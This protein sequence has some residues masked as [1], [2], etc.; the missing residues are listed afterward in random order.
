LPKGESVA[1][2]NDRICIN[3]NGLL[4]Y[5]SAETQWSVQCRDLVVLGERTNENG[6]GSPDWFVVFVT[7][8]GKWYECPV[9]TCGMKRVKKTLESTLKIRYSLQ[10]VTYTDFRSRIFYPESLAEHPLFSY[11]PVV[12]PGVLNLVARYLRIADIN[13]ELTSEV[14][15]YCKACGGNSGS[16]PCKVGP[17]DE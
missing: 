8:D 13:V 16:E 5:E 2:N 1:G 10:F 4:S 12:R 9:E 15:E 6:P 3:R 17:G 14:M 7:Y 11:S